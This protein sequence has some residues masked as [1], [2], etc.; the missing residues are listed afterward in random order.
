LSHYSLLGMSMIQNAQV[1]ATAA[2]GAIDQRRKYTGEPYI[3]HPAAVAAIVGCV[4]GHTWQMI[5]AA[6]LHDVVEDTKVELP[7]IA[8]IFGEDVGRMVEALTNVPLSAGNR[9]T[10]MVLNLEKL[11]R[12]SAEVHTIKIADLL[13]NTKS[14]VE[15][16]PKFAP[17]YLREKIAA[18]NV[19]RRGDPVLWSMAWRQCATHLRM[20]A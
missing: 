15:H 6:W 16:D 14:I 2:H 10:R 12:A 19:L 5:C 13:H 4:R 17:V 8:Q 20:I 1:F 11:S 9:A 3:T 18:L 7:V